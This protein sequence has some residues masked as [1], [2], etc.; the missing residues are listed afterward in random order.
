MVKNLPAKARDSALI[1]G[2]GRSP[3]ERKG[4]PLQYSCLRN[5][6]RGPWQAAVH[7]VAN[8]QTQLRDETTTTVFQTNFGDQ[9][10]GI[11]AK[12]DFLLVLKW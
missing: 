6:D 7:G 10:L 5:M 12:D 11:Q 8:S 2:S 1:L 9:T 3:G 4:N